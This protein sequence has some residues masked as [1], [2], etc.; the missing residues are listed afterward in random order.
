VHEIYAGPNET[1]LNPNK[2]HK[3]TS[4]PLFLQK[5]MKEITGE[6]GEE[7]KKAVEQRM[8]EILNRSTP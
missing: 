6:N 8:T 2:E 5:A 1:Y 3:S 4:R 7:F